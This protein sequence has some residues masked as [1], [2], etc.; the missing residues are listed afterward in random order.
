MGCIH[1]AHQRRRPTAQPVRSH[2]FA[3]HSVESPLPDSNRR[4]LPYHGS[5]LPTE[6]RGQKACKSA[7]SSRPNPGYARL[8]YCRGTAPGNGKRGGQRV[9]AGLSVDKD[10]PR[11]PATRRQDVRGGRSACQG[12]AKRVRIGRRAARSSPARRRRAGA[13]SSR[14]THD[15]PPS[16]GERVTHVARRPEAT[17][18][19]TMRVPPDGSGRTSAKRSQRSARSSSR[20]R[21]ASSGR[22]YR[23]W[24]ARETSSTVGHR[25]GYD[26]TSQFSREV[27]LNLL[28]PRAARSAWAASRRREAHRSA[29]RGAAIFNDA[30]MGCGSRSRGSTRRRGR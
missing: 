25:V 3:G 23:C 22:A 11:A 8:P 13:L 29:R 30:R 27:I 1:A 16:A 4:P 19:T 20:S 7:S 21:S 15:R 9:D 2:P 18:P 14:P 28:R 10:G 24:R 5:A 6:L 17:C 12:P 26:S